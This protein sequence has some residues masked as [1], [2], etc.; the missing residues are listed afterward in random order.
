M[1]ASRPSC[2]A[3]YTVL[4]TMQ[5]DATTRP[6]ATSN[7]TR[8]QPQGVKALARAALARNQQCN[9]SATAIE[10]AVPEDPSCTVALPSVCN[11]ATEAEP[12]EEPAFP[13]DGADT[14]ADPAAEARRQRVL[15]ML[16]DNPGYR[17]ALI[18]DLESDPEVAIIALAIRGRASCELRIPSA[19][20]DPF[21]LL[22][23][24]ERHGR[25]VH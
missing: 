1:S 25:T 9:R 10:N 3:A 4:S 6:S 19:K 15:A 13:D 21:L 24:I 8:V 5:P 17:Y 16:A 2:T 7:A 20:F 22:A 18:A 12:T 14:L 23:L 11:Y